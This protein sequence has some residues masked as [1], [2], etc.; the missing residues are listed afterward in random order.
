MLFVKGKYKKRK[1][2]VF[3]KKSDEKYNF[4]GHINYYT[5]ISIILFIFAIIALKLTYNKK[6][7]NQANS[8]TCI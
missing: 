1:K 5:I 6:N 8:N 7:I 2:K 4:L 3:I